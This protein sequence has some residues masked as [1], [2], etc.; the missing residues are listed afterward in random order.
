MPSSNF[1]SASPPRRL[2]M[3][4]G[5]CKFTPAYKDHKVHFWTNEGTP[6]IAPHLSKAHRFLLDAATSF[7]AFVQ[8]EPMKRFLAI[9]LMAFAPFLSVAQNT[10]KVNFNGTIG[11]SCTKYCGTSAPCCC[12]TVSFTVDST[13]CPVSAIQLHLRGPVCG[14]PICGAYFCSDPPPAGC[15]STTTGWAP[16]NSSNNCPP[17]CGYDDTRTWCTSSPANPGSTVTITFCV[18]FGASQCPGVYL[19]LAGITCSGGSCTPQTYPQQL[20]FLNNY[21]Y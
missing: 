18:M 21:C 20:V 15:N 5:R 19:D 10:C 7:N 14:A 2:T 1:D 6:W 16:C 13:S 4:I 8:G 11:T 9:A 3:T 12:F 17:Q